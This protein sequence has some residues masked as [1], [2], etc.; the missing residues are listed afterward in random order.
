MTFLVTFSLARSVFPLNYSI[1]LLFVSPA[2]WMCWTCSLSLWRKFLAAYCFLWAWPKFAA[3][4]EM[5][6][7]GI[8]P[9]NLFA[10]LNIGDTSSLP[11]CSATIVAS[12]K[13][14]FEFSMANMYLR[15]PRI[16]R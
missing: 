11:L 4:S 1:W 5:S 3:P 8:F 2:M 15:S 9:A 16:F 6:F 10:Y 7:S 12:Q 13:R 14:V